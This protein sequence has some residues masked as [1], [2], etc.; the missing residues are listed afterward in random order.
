M[1]ATGLIALLFSAA[2]C[3]PRVGDALP[4]F[5]LRGSDGTTVSSEALRGKPVLLDLW[6]PGCFACVAELPQ[7]QR[8][9]DAFAKD[10]LVVLGFYDKGSRRDGALIGDSADISFPLVHIGG[11]LM[12]RLGGWEFPTT[13][14]IGRDGRIQR[15][16]KGNPGE[17]RLTELASALLQQG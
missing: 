9:Q 7:L 8:I 2:A 4:E 12:H 15:I 10:G 17:E 1:R 3:G 13:M 14:L 16:L 6:S 5:Q 11:G